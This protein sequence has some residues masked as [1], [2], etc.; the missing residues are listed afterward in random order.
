VSTTVP[1]PQRTR[2]ARRTEAPPD[3]AVRTDAD[4]LHERL[5]AAGVGLCTL[6]VA[7]FL[8]FRLT[9]WAP[10]EDETLALFVGRKSLGG[11]LDTVLGHRG[12]AP[13]HFLIAWSIAH[14]GGGLGALRFVSALFTVA[15]VPLVALLGVRLAG[16]GPALAA[17][18]IVSASWVLLFHGVYGRMY[19]LFLFTS[20]LANLALLRALERGGRSWWLWTLATVLMVASHAYGALVFAAHGLYV[21]LSRTRV[22]EAIGYGALVVVLG[23]PMWRSDFVLAE[24][25]DVGVGRGGAKLHGP[26]SV[27]RYLRQVAADF[28]AGYRLALALAV[29]GAAVGLWRIVRTRPQS[30]LFIGCLFAVPVTMFLVGRF[31]NSSSPE[32][33]HLIFAAPLFALC[34]G[35]GALARPGRWQLVGAAAVL[36]LVPLELRWGHAKT[37]SLYDGEPHVRVEARHAASSLLAAISRPD[38][39]L[40]GFD[41]LFLGAWERGGDVSGTVVPRADPKLALDVLN[42]TSKPLGHA[43][44]VFDA[45]D[46]NNIAP[47]M[48]INLQ[49]PGGTGRWEAWTFGPFLI[50]RTLD[51]TR[52]VATYLQRARDAQLVGK[53][54]YLG[55]A[56]VNYDTVWR[57]Q[58]RLQRSR[59]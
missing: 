38:D 54:L 3:V 57:A 28:T 6:G 32:T 41:P 18:V 2:P 26:L 46:N 17:T 51:P 1:R 56:D 34:V 52:T 27:L 59:Q 31:G 30:G 36:A 5:F 47:R 49:F 22:R 4:P 19:S 39:V 48:R 21:L 53:R 29:C 37:P 7:L 8:A 42:G 14:L 40:F 9:A 23:S 35:A 25:F 11:L 45:S 13:L 12:G 50:L 33:R 15:S 16:R 10:H 55:D 43:L 44:F 24:R 20:L 58:L